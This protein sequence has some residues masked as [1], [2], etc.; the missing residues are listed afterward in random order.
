VLSSLTPATTPD[1]HV[2]ARSPEDAAGPFYLGSTSY[3]SSFR[4]LRTHVEDPSAGDDCI[5]V[6]ITPG[7]AT[8][9]SRLG[10]DSLIAAKLTSLSIYENL[11]HRFFHSER[12][13]SLVGP[14]ILQALPQIRIDLEGLAVRSSW[15]PICAQITE[16]TARSFKVPPTCTPSAFHSLFTGPNLR[17]EIIGLIFVIAGLQA[18]CTPP[19]DSVFDLGNGR[20][21]NKDDFIFQMIEGSNSC[22]HVCQ[23]YDCVNDLMIWLLYQNM[24]L[25][26]NYYGDNCE[27]FRSNILILGFL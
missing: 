14:L 17:W 5:H 19:E 21:I 26:S 10:I 25:Q 6:P 15:Q 16:N 13:S 1:T 27:S 24:L 7:G 2:A 20:R 18:Q 12:A 11:L 8:F 3:A 22:I 4:N 9:N 23:E